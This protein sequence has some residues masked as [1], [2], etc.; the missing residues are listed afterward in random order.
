MDN[1][2]YV[3]STKIYHT[4]NNYDTK[5]A[6]VHVPKTGGTY[7]SIPILPQNLGIRLSSFPGDM[8]LPVSKIQSLSDYSI[9]LFTI[10]RNP[11]DRVCSEYYFTID[12]V[13]KITLLNCWDED[14]PKKI[15]FIAKRAAIIMK[16]QQNYEK[17]Y[18]I[19]KNKMCIEEYLEWSAY[20]P[21]YPYY[22][23][24]KT[25]K[26]F[27]IVGITEDMD[28]T[29]K[30]LEKMYDTKS[31]GGD[32]NK[33]NTK[34]VGKLYENKYSREVFKIKNKIE[35]DIYEEAKEKFYQLSK[36]YL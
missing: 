17:I 26:D 20:N 31:G 35:Y 3:T 2:K 16:N 25:P 12:K 19:Y 24:E 15:E 30:L 8:H 6:F 32:Y 13:K 27:D 29:I 18:N 4:A 28:K 10:V 9:P 33:N 34:S 1:D 7:L 21:T 14:D 23:D 22:Y 5:V 36:E 11:Y